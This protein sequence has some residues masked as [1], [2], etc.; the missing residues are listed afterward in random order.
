MIT[1][2][3]CSQIYYR[4]SAFLELGR[5]VQE[6]CNLQTVMNFDHIFRIRDC[7]FPFR[8]SSL[9]IGIKLESYKTPGNTERGI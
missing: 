3:Y 6:L 9:T 1:G 2:S 7:E 8:T 5:D 4:D